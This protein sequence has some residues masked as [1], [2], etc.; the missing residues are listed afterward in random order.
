MTE[1]ETT[2][3]QTGA[4]RFTLRLPGLFPAI[5]LIS[6]FKALDP[7]LSVDVRSEIDITRGLY[8]TADWRLA[9]DGVLLEAKSSHLSGLTVN[10]SQ[11][12]RDGHDS[13]VRGSSKSLPKVLE[14][15]RVKNP[16]VALRAK[17]LARE[18]ALVQMTKVNGDLTTIS[19]SHT[20]HPPLLIAELMNSY[21]HSAAW[22]SISTHHE[23]FDLTSKLVASIRTQLP[24]IEWKEIQGDIWDDVLLRAGR[25]R[26]DYSPALCVSIERSLPPESV[27]AKVL[28]HLSLQIALNLTGLKNDFDE[29]Y[30]HEIRVA[31][32]R[33][34][35][36]LHFG[37]PVISEIDASSLRALCSEFASVCGIQRDLD[38][39]A[40]L[41]ASQRDDGEPPAIR[42][43]LLRYVKAMR[44]DSLRAT[45]TFLGSSSFAR[46]E[47]QLSQLV[48]ALEEASPAIKLPA[49][50]D[51]ASSHVHTQLNKVAKLAAKIDTK[52]THDE[53]H[54]L[55]KRVK[56]L[57]Y[58]L[59]I[60]SSISP[61]GPTADLLQELKTFQGAVGKFQDTCV[62]RDIALRAMPLSEKDLAS[63]GLDNVQLTR[64]LTK[65]IK[66]VKSLQSN[67]FHKEIAK[68]VRGMQRR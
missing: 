53:V 63:L 30:C 10:L 2:E 4:A 28:S 23:S 66:S 45:R 9:A 5:T 24:S 29:E 16:E 42:S 3:K 54:N 51:L 6:K 65:T 26:G 44:E 31:T 40:E 50:S 32:R 19:F 25:K 18:R 13:L 60:F 58:L 62:A 64:Q 47:L 55:R 46:F 21:Q 59:E 14:P 36:L 8:D 67:R 37:A 27:Y 35:T 68:V 56:E 49:I 34:R 11:R 41:F 20:G 15:S 57:R 1:T 7:E 17:A 48:T 12:G 33:I 38:V 61:A 22:L 52:S 39:V 43:E